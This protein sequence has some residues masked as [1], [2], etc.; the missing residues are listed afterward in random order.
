MSTP[1]TVSSSD[2]FRLTLPANAT[3][4]GG[5][6]EADLSGGGDPGTVPQDV[7]FNVSASAEFDRS[8]GNV[9]LVDATDG[10]VQLTLPAGSDEIIGL[11]FSLI[12][13][14]AG[15]N[16][17][18]FVP[19]GSDTI[20]GVSELA[21][22]T[23]NNRLNIEW[24]GDM[25]RRTDVALGISNF[26]TTYGN[27][28]GVSSPKLS[29]QAIGANEQI[30]TVHLTSVK[31]A[32]AQVGFVSWPYTVAFGNAYCVDFSA[33]LEGTTDGNVIL[34]V[35]IN[36]TPTTP[37]MTIPAGAAG[38]RQHVV[39]LTANDIPALG[40]ITVAVTGANTNA[41]GCS[42]SLKCII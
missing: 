18:S 5:V 40:Y 21:T 34:T 31:A 35:G 36:G 22:A 20:E 38:S 19:S 7:F 29:R 15:A 41:V 11:K 37:A 6:V 3:V 4:E 24:A 28:T 33:V 13:T 12:K 9:A 1:V 32:D 39:L 16:D 2:T 30:L 25:W 10:D 8:L 42:V 14:D 23:E 26:L 27:L 17:A